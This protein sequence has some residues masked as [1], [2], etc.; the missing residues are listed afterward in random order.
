MTMAEPKRR[1]VKKAAVG[2]WEEAINLNAYFT[3]RVSAQ[4]VFEHRCGD[5]AP[6]R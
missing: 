5:A 2:G 4:K 3:E 6:E 1:A